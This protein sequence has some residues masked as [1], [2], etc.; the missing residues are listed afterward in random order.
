MKTI[1]NILKKIDTIVATIVMAIIFFDV[2]LRI[3]SRVLPGNAI[4]WTVELGEVLLAALIWFG[5]SAGISN[6]SH[7]AFDI[8]LKNRSKKT[9][10]VVGIL[11]NLLF[12]AY[13]ALL[14][15]MTFNLLNFYIIKGT[16]TTILGIPM[17]MVRL[18]ILLGSALGIIHLIFK[19][20]KVITG[21]I[22]MF[23]NSI[24]FENEI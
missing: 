6:D 3:I 4:S 19:T 15:F 24:N 7:V 17:Y 2:L 22:E 21:E 23:S 11:S 16:T 8:F 18:P 9:K 1:T 10:K 5:M 12:I 13:L 20:K 14:G